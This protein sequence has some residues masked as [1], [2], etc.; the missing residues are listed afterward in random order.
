M[1]V[2]WVRSCYRSTWRLF[3]NSLEETAGRYYFRP[4]GTPHLPVP[5]F[6][7]SRNWTTEEAFTDSTRG[8]TDLTP[9]P[10][11]NGAV[12]AQVPLVQLVGSKLCFEQGEEFPHAQVQRT[13]PDGID[14][15]CYT[16]IPPT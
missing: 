2:E 11:E 5:H 15:R 1:A 3:K 10:W 12:P 16:P 4:E 14:S 9:R 7:G 6:F 8:E 13:L